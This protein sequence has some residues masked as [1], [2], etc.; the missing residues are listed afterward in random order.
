MINLVFPTAQCF[1][2][3]TGDTARVAQLWGFSNVSLQEPLSRVLALDR[4]VFKLS[5]FFIRL[6]NFIQWLRYEA[7]QIGEPAEVLV[8]SSKAGFDTFKVNLPLLLSFCLSYLLRGQQD[9]PNNSWNEVASYLVDH[10]AKLSY[11]ILLVPMRAH[12]SHYFESLQCYYMAT[13]QQMIQMSIALNWSPPTGFFST[14]IDYICVMCRHW[15]RCI[16]QSQAFGCQSILIS[17]ATYS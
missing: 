7:V 6:V 15:R 10:E 12:W 8:L 14:C 17:I 9:I 3:K 4:M 2:V 11:L 5:S 13:N 16:S 1:K